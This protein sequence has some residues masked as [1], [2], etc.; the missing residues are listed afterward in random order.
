MDLFQAW[1]E[2]G[3]GPLCS[4]LEPP[5]NILLLPPPPLPPFLRHLLLENE[6]LTLNL[7][8][9]ECNL[10]NLFRDESQDSEFVLPRPTEKGSADSMVSV[11]GASILGLGFGA[12]LLILIWCKK[13]KIFP[14][15]DSCPIFPETWVPGGHKT[16]PPPSPTESCISPVVNEKSP[17]SIIMDSC[18]ANKTSIPS[19]YWRRG[20][21]ADFSSCH[22]GEASGGNSVRMMN[23]DPGMSE[24][25]YADGGSCTSSPVYAELDGSVPTAMAG[26]ILVSG[27]SISPYAVG[28]KN[29]PEAL[30]MASLAPGPVGV[31][32][33]DTSYDNAAYLPSATSDLY[34]SRSLRRSSHRASGQMACAAPLLAPHPQF[35]GVTAAYLTG[36]RHSRKSS[37]PTFAQH[38]ARSSIQ[39]RMMMVQDND[40]QHHFSGDVLSGDVQ[41][42]TRHAA[43]RSQGLYSDL[44]LHSSPSLSTFKTVSG[45]PYGYRT[46]NPKRPLPPVP[47]VRL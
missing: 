25:Q 42:M 43:A 32:P 12:F 47:G 39:N 2:T 38:L 36:G 6:S 35:S 28:L 4:L 45:S 17:Q 40:P 30:R 5:P 18:H 29:Y 15:K 14:A 26:S 41:R 34:Q 22:M 46:D 9:G 1:N 44:P 33:Q 16:A 8:G 19:K 13:W 23:D 20:G 10:C 11:I 21:G 24:E 31:V 7:N 37:R 3:C 27:H